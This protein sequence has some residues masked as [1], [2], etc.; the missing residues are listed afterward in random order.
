[1]PHRERVVRY[2]ETVMV[3]RRQTVKEIY[4]LVAYSL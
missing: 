4:A 3:M 1:M 2:V